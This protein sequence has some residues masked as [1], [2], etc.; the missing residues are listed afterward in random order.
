MR[1]NLSDACKIE[2]QTIVLSKAAKMGNALYI[3]NHSGDVKILDANNNDISQGNNQ[4]TSQQA[5]ALYDLINKDV[6]RTQTADGYIRMRPTHGKKTYTYTV[7][8]KKIKVD[9]SNLF[10]V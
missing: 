4:I 10:I 1:N 8:D 7:Q 6:T 5:Q 9:F 2:T 3:E